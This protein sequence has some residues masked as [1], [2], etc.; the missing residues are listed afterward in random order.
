MSGQG[1]E[2]TSAASGDVAKWQSN[3]IDWNPKPKRRRFWKK[4]GLPIHFDFKNRAL[5]QRRWN[6]MDGWMMPRPKTMLIRYALGS[7]HHARPCEP[8]LLEPRSLS[9][10]QLA[11][12]QCNKYQKSK[13]Q[14]WYGQEIAETIQ[15]SYSQFHDLSQHKPTQAAQATLQPSTFQGVP[16]W[17]WDDLGCCGILNSVAH[18]KTKTLNPDFVFL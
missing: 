8:S 13:D 5:T 16:H 15:L 14:V 7:C 10:T 9:S 17:V 18:Y 3:S 12:I 11:K 2:P 1:S 4:K 6:S